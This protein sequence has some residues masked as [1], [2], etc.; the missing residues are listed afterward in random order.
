M[1]SDLRHTAFSA[2]RFSDILRRSYRA[3]P[4]ISCFIA[5]ATPPGISSPF[6]A[7]YYHTIE[8]R[9]C[10]ALFRFILQ[11][12]GVFFVRNADFF[13]MCCFMVILPAF[14]AVYTPVS[15]SLQN[16]AAQN[17]AR[18]SPSSLSL[19]KRGS[20]ALPLLT[21]LNMPRPSKPS[22]PQVCRRSRTCHPGAPAQRGCS[23]WTCRPCPS[24]P[25]RR[26]DRRT[27][28]S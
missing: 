9:G 17:T 12:F 8:F 22:S 27:T 15:R 10:Q 6:R 14:S 16:R 1:R 18:K 4:A 19:Q 26:P 11:T 23:G 13:L 20:A 3:K 28:W 21:I 5:F 2:A 25:S 24:S 7:L